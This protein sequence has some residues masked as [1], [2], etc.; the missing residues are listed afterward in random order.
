[1]GSLRSHSPHVRWSEGEVEMLRQHYAEA[2]HERL[3][4]LLPGRQLRVIQC[5][6]NA[7]GLVRNRCPAR[8][9]EE[10][11]E[12]KR[13]HMAQ[14]RVSDP[15]GARAYARAQ[16]HRNRDRELSAMRAYQARRF[17]WNKARK[18]T[19]PNS[20][21]A[22]DLA[23]LWKAQ[24]GLCALTGRRLD[25]SA[26]LDHKLARARGGGDHLSNF[27]WL[28]EEA[29]LAK[30]A[31]TDAEFIALCADVTAWIGRRIAAV[32]ALSLQAEAA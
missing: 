5:K 23:A 28:C 9:P 10:R 6:A 7:L 11:R 20:A 13:L 12:A 1:M 26:Q 31:L 2:T 3:L 18:L 29:N 17:F 21:T 15:D 24:K 30:R 19:G 22:Q 25:R 4:A 32:E 27:Q 16:Y 8:T 14:R